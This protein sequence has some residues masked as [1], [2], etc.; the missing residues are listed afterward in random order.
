VA[1]TKLSLYN[2]A[3]LLCGL[4]E[5]SS[6]TEDVPH[7][8]DLDRAYDDAS[9]NDLCLELV[10]PTFAT[11]VAKIA[12]GAASSEHLLAQTYDLDD[13]SDYIAF[14]AAYDSGELDEKITRY[15]IEE[16]TLYCDVGTNIWVRYVAQVTTFASWTPSFTNVVAAYL[17]KTIASRV[18]PQ[19][20][21]FLEKLF[22]SNIQAAIEVDSE[23]ESTPRPPSSTF[24]LTTDYLNVYNGALNL[25]GKPHII[26]IN[27]DSEIRVALDTVLDSGAVNYLYEIVKPRFA[28]ETNMMTSSTTSSH[29]DLD[30]VFTLP[31]DYLAICELHADPLMD[32]PITRYLIEARTLA[33]TYSTIYI[34]F[35]SSSP[36]TSDWTPGYTQLLSAYLADQVKNRFV[37]DGDMRK[38]ITAEFEKRLEYL[39]QKEGYKETERA[40]RTTATLTTEWRKIYNHAFFIMGL[41]E[42]VSNDDD[43]IRRSKV[44]VALGTGIVEAALEDMGWTFALTSQKVT[45]DPSLEPDWGYIRVFAKPNDMHRIHGVYSDG[46]FRSPLK[47]Y[48]DEGDQ[49][50]AHIDDIYVQYVKTSFLTD[51]SSWPQYFK[52]VIASKLADMTCSVLKGDKKNTE[53]KVKQFADEAESTDA[54]RGPPQPIHTGRWVR[55]QFSGRSGYDRL[56]P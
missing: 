19:K 6:D 25:L 22:L 29:H 37:E 1:V 34:R 14:I 40:T 18:S 24:T 50:F 10:K 21:A 4:R 55:S 44:D 38:D 33:C 54:L 51:P 32:E 39:I 17:A 42:I 7:R 47:D 12:P 28:L 27:D 35:I 56:R 23:R 30:N 31:S 46:H 43:S 41:P 15:I 20:Q 9:A 49:W 48:Q 26:S 16:Q 2:D 13:N 52:N 5:L 3:L 53:D 45:F 36:A 11:K 8:Y